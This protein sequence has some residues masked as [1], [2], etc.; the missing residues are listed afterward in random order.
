MT[1]DKATIDEKYEIYWNEQKI[2]ELGSLGSHF[3]QTFKY[4]DPSPNYGYHEVEFDYLFSP[5][6][7]YKVGIRPKKVTKVFVYYRLDGSVYTRRYE[8]DM[9]KEFKKIGI[10]VF[11]LKSEK[12]LDL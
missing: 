6:W 7:R 11:K 2:G 3:V 9:M 12:A 5:N 4:L 8:K 10:P 1:T